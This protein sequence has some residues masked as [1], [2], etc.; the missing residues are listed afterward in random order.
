MSSTRMNSVSSSRYDIIHQYRILRP[1][2]NSNETAYPCEWSD[3]ALG[4]RLHQA[5]GSLA[6]HQNLY[7]KG[8]QTMGAYHDGSRRLLWRCLSDSLHD[9]VSP[10]LSAMGSGAG[11]NMPQHCRPGADLCVAQHGCRY[12]NCHYASACSLE[13]PAGCSLKT[14]RLRHV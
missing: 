5:V 14:G 8:L 6:L 7:H 4:H 10:H 9:S 13:P 2:L 3:M 1:K 12:R 11:R